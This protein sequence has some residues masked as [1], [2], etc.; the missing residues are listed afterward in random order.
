MF[1]INGTDY[2]LI[3][4]GII[5]AALFFAVQYF[6]CGKARSLGV[7]LIPVYFI[8]IILVLAALVIAGDRG[9]TFIEDIRG[10]VAL[11]ILGFA[12]VCGISTGAAWVVY[13]ARNKK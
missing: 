6:L 11:V 8:L 13:R 4:V 5:A 1:V 10:V 3:V 2:S 12:L 9:D 7:K